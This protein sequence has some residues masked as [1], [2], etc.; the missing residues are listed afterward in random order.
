MGMDERRPI[1][2]LRLIA[3]LNVGGPAIHVTLLTEKLGAPAFEHVLACGQIAPGEGDMAYYAE[4]H[5][6]QPVMIPALGRALH[7]ARDLVTWWHVYR[8][9]RRLRPDVVHTHTAKA[10]FVGRMAAWLFRVTRRGRVPVVV[11]TY[12]GHVFSGYFSQNTTRVFLFLE[13][14][15]AR[16]S[17]A[18]ITLT[19]GLRD[20]LVNT[21]RIAPAEK[22]RVLSLGLDLDRF[23]EQP[24][25]AGAFRREHGIAADAPLIGIVGRLVP[26]KNHALFLDAAARVCA[27]RSDAQFA[28]IGDGELRAALEAQVNALGLADVVRFT[29]WVR[30]LAPAYS[31]LDCNV[32]SSLNEG[33]PVSVIEALA[34]G[35]P[36]VATRVGG[37]DDLLEGGALGMLVPSGDAAALADAIVRSLAAP[38]G[39]ARQRQAIRDR[40]HIDR[41][42]GELAAL[43]RELL[44][45]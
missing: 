26:V 19:N 37:L 20:E 35:C 5:S 8:L 2:I 45:K 4:A 31:D 21:Y 44:A 7:P 39:D 29:G 41:L 14:L 28:I 12:H 43:Y 16:M 22:F 18:L 38:P 40:Y 13:R 24:R 17:D 34:A 33:T 32:I 1:R 15:T 23:L 25:K 27:H 36:V 42:A 3:R 9:M 6:V 30:D 10:G 11:H